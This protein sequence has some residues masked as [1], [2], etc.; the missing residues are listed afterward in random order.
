MVL[1]ADGSLQSKFKYAEKTKPERRHHFRLKQSGLTSSAG[2]AL[3][4]E[5]DRD[6]EDMLAFIPHTALEDTQESV[7]AKSASYRFPE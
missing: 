3:D 2:S 1:A 7:L 5:K 4:C 6:P